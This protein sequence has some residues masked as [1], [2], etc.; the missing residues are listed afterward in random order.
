MPAAANL[1]LRGND[2]H[3]GSEGQEL[4]SPMFYTGKL[5]MRIPYNGVVVA[6][7]AFIG[8]HV[9]DADKAQVAIGVSVAYI[10]LKR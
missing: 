4:R 3:A 5:I 9:H 6:A 8:P 10:R 7:S 1:R 2:A